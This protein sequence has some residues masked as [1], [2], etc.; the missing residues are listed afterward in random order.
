VGPF[1]QYRGVE[2]E[3]SLA[4]ISC[5]LFSPSPSLLPSPSNQSL[6]TMSLHLGGITC[7]GGMMLRSLK[8]EVREVWYSPG[9]Q[10]RFP[11]RFRRVFA[12][13]TEL[14][15][16]SVNWNGGT[17]GRSQGISQRQRPRLVPFRG[18]S[19]QRKRPT[20]ESRWNKNRIDRV[21]RPW[22]SKRSCLCE[23]SANAR[24]KRH[25]VF[26]TKPPG[27]VADDYCA[28][29]TWSGEFRLCRNQSREQ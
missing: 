4:E 18:S 1:L 13:L 7:D 25:G 21:C 17:W 24:S 9:A 20:R 19:S 6:C 15:V 5:S 2:A 16:F 12:M 11:F 8:L 28:G 14:P 22:T 26:S 29:S 27:Y 10:V 23:D 3:L